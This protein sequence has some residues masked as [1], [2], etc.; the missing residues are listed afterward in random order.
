MLKPLCSNVR[1]IAAEVSGD[2][3]LGFLRYMCLHFQWYSFINLYKFELS[4]DKTNKMA[5]AP[6][7]D[8]DQ[9]GN[10]PR[11]I[12]VLDAQADQS[13]LST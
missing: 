3:I 5:C 7:E 9:P 4:H 8:S 2:R 6:S 12:R 1:I 13:S 11:L 10:P